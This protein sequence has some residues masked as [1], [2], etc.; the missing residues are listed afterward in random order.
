MS[1]ITIHLNGKSQE[2]PEGLTLA[3][4]I[5]WLKFPADRLAVERNR[6]IV[7]RARWAET[8]LQA[9]D[10]LEVVHLVGGGIDD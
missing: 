6:E 4:L 8:P 5:E 3:G 2:V 9:G 7:P 1:V 10:E